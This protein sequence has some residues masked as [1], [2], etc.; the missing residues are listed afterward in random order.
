[1]CVRRFVVIWL[2]ESSNSLG[3]CTIHLSYLLLSTCILP[4]YHFSP[5]TSWIQPS[6][7]CVPNHKHLSCRPSQPCSASS[8]CCKLTFSISLCLPVT[9]SKRTRGCPNL[10]Y[11]NYCCK[12]MNVGLLHHYCPEITTL[13]FQ[14][15]IFVDYSALCKLYLYMKYRCVLHIE[16]C[17]CIYIYITI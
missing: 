9:H 16:V 1:M 7:I 11:C 17:G 6:T 3:I 15:M 5:P 12:E 8:S 2:I 4:N 13:G 10:L 14:R